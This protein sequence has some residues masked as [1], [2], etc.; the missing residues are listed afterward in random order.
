[1]TATLSALIAGMAAFAVFA[2][3]LNRERIRDARWRWLAKQAQ[4]VGQDH[5]APAED[6]N[7]PLVQR[8]RE[9]GL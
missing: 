9:A 7:K 5:A 3:W 6:S 1:M 8:L 4:P 2:I